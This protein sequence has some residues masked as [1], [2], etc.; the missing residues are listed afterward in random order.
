MLPILLIKQK[1]NLLPKMMDGNVKQRSEL[2][3]EGMWDALKDPWRN[4]SASRIPVRVTLNPVSTADTG[5]LIPLQLSN[6]GK[7]TQLTQ[8]R[9]DLPPPRCASRLDVATETACR[10]DGD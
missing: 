6:L 1:G 10:N 2:E 9:T 5:Y 3:L 7:G 8:P 4:W